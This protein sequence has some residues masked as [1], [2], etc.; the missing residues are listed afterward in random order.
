MAAAAEDVEDET[1]G[2]VGGVG[3]GVAGDPR[4]VNSVPLCPV[5]LGTAPLPPLLPL[6]SLKPPRDD[7]LAPE[8]A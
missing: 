3:P 2:T 4:E 8:A 6:A 1:E 5:E 7:S